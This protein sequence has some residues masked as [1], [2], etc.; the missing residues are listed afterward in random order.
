M[1]NTFS[2][3]FFIS[4]VLL[5][6]SY[7][8]YA[9]ETVAGST[10]VSTLLEPLVENYNQPIHKIDLQS[11][12]SSAGVNL[13]ANNTINLAISSRQLTPS[14]KKQYSSQLIAYDAIAIVV[15]P[16]NPIASLSAENI[17]KIYHGDISNW[18][19][20]GGED[21]DIAVI[22]R[23]I[24]SGSRF[25]FER[26][27]GLTKEINAYTVS[28]IS[29]NAIV[30]NGTG[31]VKS[32]VAQNPY[33]IGYISAGSLKKMKELR[34]V[35]VDNML[36]NADSI[37]KKQYPLARP[38]LFVYKPEKLSQASS[39]FINYIS[40]KETSSKIKALGYVTE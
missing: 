40:S 39:E 27:L 34:V 37:I 17:W 15:H 23:E 19:Q 10:S 2:R 1:L 28:D 32:I 13:L 26:H 12:G 14:E 31:M 30:V 18:N 8:S 3:T 6:S 7:G 5:T 25:S 20:V 11:I 33:A 29:D 38:F 21:K 22:T 36:P 16:N 24:A 4:S 35:K 9:A